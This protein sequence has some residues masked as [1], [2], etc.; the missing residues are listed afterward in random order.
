MGELTAN[1]GLLCSLRCPAQRLGV[2]PSPGVQKTSSISAAQLTAPCPYPFDL[3]PSRS[4]TVPV[5]AEAWH[6]DRT[7][8]RKDDGRRRSGIGRWPR[9]GRRRRR[10]TGCRRPGDGAGHDRRGGR[11]PVGGAFECPAVERALALMPGMPRTGNSWNFSCGTT[12]LVRSRGSSMPPRS[13]ITP[14]LAAT[15]GAQYCRG[16]DAHWEAI[17]LGGSR[18]PRSFML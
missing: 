10:H 13:R 14:P 8:V 16:N 12:A 3:P 9:I 17:R 11:G 4:V 15:D 7:R 5:E 1:G 6:D 18:R 2:P